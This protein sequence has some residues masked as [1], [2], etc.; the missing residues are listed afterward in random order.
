MTSKTSIATE[1][2]WKVYVEGDGSGC[3]DGI[4]NA[5]A[6]NTLSIVAS[7]GL[8]RIHS[9]FAQS[10]IRVYTLDGKLLV[11]QHLIHQDTTISVPFDGA[12]IV[13][14]TDDATGNSTTTKVM[15]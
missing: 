2:N 4:D 1:K 7:E 11:Q 6:D 12:C 15:L 9:P 3:A 13:R 10:T 14:C 8:L 5:D